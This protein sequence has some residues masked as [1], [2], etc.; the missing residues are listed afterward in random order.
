MVANSAI[1]GS[2]AGDDESPELSWSN[3]P[4]GTRSFVVIAYDVTASFTHWAMY[5]ISPKTRELPENAGVGGSTYGIQVG[6]DFGDLSYDGPCPPPAYTPA[7]HS[8]VFTVYALDIVL[9][10]L[11]T[12]GDFT[13]G[14]EALYHALIEGRWR[15]H[16]L[17]SASIGGVFPGGS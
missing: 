4:R 2:F 13:P 7:S 17:D 8:Y 12:F 15:N 9:P 16:I 1:C 3:V 6:N 10:V 14:S 5:N 11:P